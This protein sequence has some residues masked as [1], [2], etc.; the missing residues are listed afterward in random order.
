[1]L[2]VLNAHFPH[3]PHR[4][5]HRAITSVGAII[6]NVIIFVI[7]ITAIIIVIDICIVIAIVVGIVIV[8]ATVVVIAVVCVVSAIA[9]SQDGFVL[10]DHGLRAS[11]HVAI[12]SAAL[13]GNCRRGPMSFA[14]QV[15]GGWVG[16][17]HERG[18]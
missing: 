7:I 11:A 9:R 12:C 5:H 4:P 14:E 17:L 6:V 8:I 1:M 10:R 2:D 15:A 18:R 13:L 3:Q 16:C